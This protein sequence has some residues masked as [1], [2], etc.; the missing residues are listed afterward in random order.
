MHFEK[1]QTGGHIILDQGDHERLKVSPEVTAIPIVSNEYD[2]IVTGL[3]EYLNSGHVVLEGYRRNRSCFIFE[4]NA[5]L[6]A[7]KGLLAELHGYQ[8]LAAQPG[9]TP[10]HDSERWYA[11]FHEPPIEYPPVIPFPARNPSF[12]PSGPSIA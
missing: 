1:T 8:S 11:A 7:A 9:V 3:E 10:Q 4:L 6:V 2:A 5:E 12:D